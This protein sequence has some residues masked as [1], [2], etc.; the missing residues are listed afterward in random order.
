MTVILE[1][2]EHDAQRILVLLKQQKE[3]AEPLW[4]DYWKRLAERVGER[5]G[6]NYEQRLR[7][8]V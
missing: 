8:G 1:L 7:R 2:N 5:I 4:R 6:R 3:Q